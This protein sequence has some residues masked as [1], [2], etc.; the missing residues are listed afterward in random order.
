MNAPSFL[1]YYPRDKH[2]ER[3]RKCRQFLE[4]A[5]PVLAAPF[6]IDPPDIPACFLHFLLGAAV[7]QEGLFF[8]FL[9]I[10]KGGQGRAIKFPGTKG[11]RGFRG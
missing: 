3:A 11:E 10:E 2:R 1:Q 5:L 7:P 8:F 4:N 6:D 9:A